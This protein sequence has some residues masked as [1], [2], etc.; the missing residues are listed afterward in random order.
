M[1]P[2]A[3]AIESVPA[4]RHGPWGRY[5]DRHIDELRF[6]FLGFLRSQSPFFSAAPAGNSARRCPPPSRPACEISARFPGF[7]VQCDALHA[8]MLVSK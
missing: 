8:A 1:P 6:T 2:S 5:R 3:W 4:D 7:Q